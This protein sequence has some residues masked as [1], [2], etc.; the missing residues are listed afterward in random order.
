MSHE[1]ETLAYVGETPWHGLGVSVQDPLIAVSPQRFLE[2]AELDWK[3][4][5]APVITADRGEATSHVAIRRASDSKIL[6]VVGRRY[7]PLQ[8]SSLV[9][10]FAPFIESGMARF[11]SAGSLKGGSVVFA[12]AKI[13]SL[14][15]LV[16]SDDTVKAYVLLSHAHD[17]TH[18]IRGGFTRI[19]TI[20]WNTLSS[21]WHS[22]DSK[23]IR[24]K[25]SKNVE[26]NLAIVRE[27]MD[28]A[29]QEF[30][31]TLSLYRQLATREINRK[32]V[33]KYVKILLGVELDTP[34]K[35]LTHH[36]R[37]VLS[38]IETLTYEGRGNTGETWW[39]AYNG[40][41][42]Y[43]NYFDGRSQDSRLRSLWFGE[44]HMTS[45]KALA[46]ATELALQ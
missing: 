34:E 8:N 15:E 39:D 7:E 25:H 44:N 14:E 12:L 4:E 5:K 23:L 3:V 33:Q 22:A 11:E 20:C 9:E 2:A 30:Q 19:R 13:L 24:V 6:G 21:A 31:A 36:T 37:K 38:S 45:E 18:A 16:R 10:W 40:V 35:D 46:V 27:A 42:E 32:D 41:T 29:T 26:R 1:V 17:G 43:L 28:L